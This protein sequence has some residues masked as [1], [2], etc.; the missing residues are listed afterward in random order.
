MQKNKL[1]FL[2]I[3]GSPKR[4]NT[5]TVL[6]WVAEGA[7]EAGGT[8]E[9]IDI[10]DLN[11]GY[12]QGCHTCLRTG[13]CPVKDDMAALLQKIEV[14]DGIIVGSPVYDGYPSA[15]MKTV[16]DRTALLKLYTGIL[17]DKYTIG[18]ATSGIAPTKKTAKK[19]AMTFGRPLGWIGVKT[20]T[21]SG[22]YQKI[23]KESFHKKYKK[24]RELG[25]ELVTET[26]KGSK[27]WSL[28]FA[29]IN[30]LRKHMLKKLVVNNKDQF[31]GV[32]KVFKEKSWL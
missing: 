21:I 11:I 16:I 4:R 6:S 18:V 32:V 25:K 10:A 26:K 2:V 7:E 14:S 19:V 22:G 5:Y 3:N 20:A 1:H 28:K 15:Q 29:W 31:G 13:E 30:F 8:T 27:K 17:E 23:S 12:C 24:A 9:Y